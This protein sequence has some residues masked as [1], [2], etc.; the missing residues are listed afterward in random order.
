MGT[1]DSG[2]VRNE[3]FVLPATH[4]NGEYC[5]RARAKRGLAWETKLIGTRCNSTEVA[6]KALLEIRPTDGTGL[7]LHV[8]SSMRVT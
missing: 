5:R 2:S 1:H 7:L 8:T 6:V 4:Y 3:N